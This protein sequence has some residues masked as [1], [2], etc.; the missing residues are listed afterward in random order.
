[1]LLIHKEVCQ[2]A[3]NEQEGSM[4]PQLRLTVSLDE[5]AKNKVEELKTLYEKDF[6]ITVSYANVIR[7]A[8]NDA[9]RLVKSKSI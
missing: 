9:L 4:T 3:H 5:E 2:P 1:M 7:L 8:V 6:G